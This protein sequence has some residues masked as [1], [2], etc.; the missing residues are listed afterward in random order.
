MD[1]IMID[2]LVLDLP[3]MTT[4][5]AGELTKRIGEGLAAASKTGGSF[6]SLTIDLNEQALSRDLPHLAEN[7]VDAIMR[8]IG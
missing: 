6:G 1:E 4:A 5:R 3:G 2:R 8:Q 7:I